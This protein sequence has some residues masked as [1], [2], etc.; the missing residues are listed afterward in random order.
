MQRFSGPKTSMLSLISL[1][2][3]ALVDYTWAQMWRCLGVY[4]YLWL[5]GHKRQKTQTGAL[6]VNMMLLVL[7]TQFAPWPT[8]HP[9]PH[10]LTLSHTPIH[11]RTLTHTC[12]CTHTHT[13]TSLVISVFCPPSQKHHLSSSTLPPSLT[14]EWK[15]GH[16]DLGIQSDSG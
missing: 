3:S 16:D 7:H 9:I 10:I 2:S 13:Q 15:R 11:R 12:F 1:Q 14:P 4:P 8:F 5:C 6:G